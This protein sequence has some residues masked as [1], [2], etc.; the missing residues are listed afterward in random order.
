MAKCLAQDQKAIMWHKPE[1][2]ESRAHVS[3]VTW[4]CLEG[5]EGKTLKNLGF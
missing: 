4:E 2:S 5:G 3:T 1:E